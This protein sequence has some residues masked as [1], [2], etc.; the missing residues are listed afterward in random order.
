MDA[1]KEGLL[2]GAIG[3]V[4]TAGLFAALWYGSQTLSDWREQQRL[5]YQQ[6]LAPWCDYASAPAGD[7]TVRPY[8]GVVVSS[9]S[10]LGRYG[11]S[12][13]VGRVDEVV[14]VQ[15][16]EADRPLAL[17]HRA[18]DRPAPGTVLRFCGITTGDGYWWPTRGWQTG[19][20]SGRIYGE[21]VGPFN[22]VKWIR[23][24]AG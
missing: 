15:I 23:D 7:W 21:P 24:L 13:P 14:F 6:E 18:G 22:T 12:E 10:S 4:L 9:P 16:E 5:A 11:R 19:R 17:L 3:L 20:N 8:Q 1:R 2:G